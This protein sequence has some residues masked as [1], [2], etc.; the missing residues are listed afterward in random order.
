MY[1]T[2]APHTLWVQPC[3]KLHVSG[4]PLFPLLCVQHRPLLVHAATLSHN[5]WLVL[6][7]NGGS[8]VNGKWHM[9]GRWRATSFST[10][11]HTGAHTRTQLCA[12]ICARHIYFVTHISSSLQPVT[13][14]RGLIHFLPPRI[15]MAHYITQI[16][17][18]DACQTHQDFSPSPACYCARVPQTSD[19]RS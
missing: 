16:K 18:V 14:S 11:S 15:Q 2:D 10:L 19:V 13:A 17:W 8:L 1:L 12:S 4:F 5:T 6:A 9:T 7:V 3:L